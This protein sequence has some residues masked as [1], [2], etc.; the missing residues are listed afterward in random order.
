MTTPDTPAL[1]ALREAE[2]EALEALAEEI[3]A[4]FSDGFVAATAPLYGTL[5]EAVDA[6]RDA[7]ERR[8]WQ[9]RSGTYGDGR[10]DAAREVERQARA[11]VLA[12]GVNA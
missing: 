12:A 2:W 10:L 6:Y 3:G 7:V 11:A 1:A 9:S 4:L 5:A 8:V